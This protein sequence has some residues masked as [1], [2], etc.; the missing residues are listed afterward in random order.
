MP[1]WASNKHFVTC[2]EGSVAVIA[3]LAIT[4]LML[5]AGIAVDYGNMVSKRN[6]LQAV[7]DA[8]SIAV[9]REMTLANASMSEL[10]AVANNMVTLKTELAD[11]SLSV[12]VNIDT[13]DSSAEVVLT[14]DWAPFFAHLLSDAVTPI[15]AQATAQV[16][17]GGKICVIGLEQTQ[18]RTVH[19]RRNAQ[20][21]ADDCGVYSNSVSND[22][23]RV[24]DSGN[25]TADLIC[26]SGG[27][28]GAPSAY[29]P[30]ATTDCPP[31]PD[32]LVDRV[33]PA[34]GLCDFTNFEATGASMT[35]TPGVYCGG[36]RASAS[37][38]VTFEPGIYI[39]KD[40]P[41][42]AQASATFQGENV[43]F[44]LT[45]TDTEIRFS[46]NTSISLTAPEDGELAG[47]LFFEDRN[48]SPEH[49]HRITSND[50][51]L[52]LGTL[53]LPVSRLFVDANAPV[54]DQSAYTAIIARM[55]SLDAGPNLVLNS[56]YGSTDI[57]VPGNLS[58]A[59]GRIV[60]TE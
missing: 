30:S 55:L 31:V 19:L 50:A 5:G 4:A 37:T 14:E 56:D 27:A 51:R 58:S 59:G 12:S 44:Y 11:S 42:E 8:A 15:T 48:N 20:L 45:G 29:N 24:D 10:E 18:N 22:S 41:L 34:V 35:L 7:A 54:A 3:A 49:V 2:H 47:L 16:V 17:S 28:G 52:L 39:I 26:S 13:G 57:P 25:M 46:S 60:L 21:T 23:I 6:T 43:G 40:G 32:P 53:Y 36:L 33:P 9:A 1:N 38:V